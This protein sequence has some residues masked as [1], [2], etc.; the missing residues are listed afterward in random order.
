VVPLL[1]GKAWIIAIP[2]FKAFSTYSIIFGTMYLAIASLLAFR[3]YT[4]M[5]IVRVA[6]LVLFVVLLFTAGIG[7]S[8]VMVAVLLQVAL[9]VQAAIL[10]ITVRKE[11]FGQ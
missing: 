10:W 3:K 8:G 4:L 5:A 11:Y 1:F 7:S 2:Y 9:L 6:C